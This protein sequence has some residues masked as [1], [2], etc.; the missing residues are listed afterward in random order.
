MSITSSKKAKMNN[1][2]RIAKLERTV[3]LRKPE[4]KKRTF[5][6]STVNLANGASAFESITLIPQGANDIER[7]GNEIK[8]TKIDVVWYSGSNGTD[9]FLLGN[10][11]SSQNPSTGAM[12]GGAHPLRTFDDDEFKIYRHDIVNANMHTNRWSV[13]FPNGKLIKYDGGSTSAIN[14][15]MFFHINNYSGSTSTVRAVI[16]VFYLDA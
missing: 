7:L 14:T 4:Q 12:V 8:I 6:S 5:V 2:D 16:E 1:A 3:A 13:K 9:V 15:K 11:D 10:Y